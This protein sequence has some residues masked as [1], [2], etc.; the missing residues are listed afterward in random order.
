MTNGGRRTA[1]EMSEITNEQVLLAI[2][3]LRGEME[4]LMVKAVPAP[5]PAGPDVEM[6]R[7][8]LEELHDYIRR[9]KL[10]VAA[11]RHPR[12]GSDRLVAATCELDAVVGATEQATNGILQ[13]AEEIEAL[14]GRLRNAVQ[15]PAASEIADHMTDA[16]MKIFEHCGFQDITGQRVNKVVNTL[17]YIEERIGSIVRIWGEETFHA[18]PLPSGED[19]DSDRDLLN[20]P[21]LDGDSVS[22]SMID[23]LLAAMEKPADPAVGRGSTCPLP[24]VAAEADGEIKLAEKDLAGRLRIFLDYEIEWNDRFREMNSDGAGLAAL[25][26]ERAVYEHDLGIEALVGRIGHLREVRTVLSELLGM[27]ASGTPRDEVVARVLRFFTVPCDDGIASDH[28]LFRMEALRLADGL[29]EWGEMPEREA[30]L[31]MEI[32][33]SWRN[34]E[35][36]AALMTSAERTAE[37]L[38]MIRA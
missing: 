35:A 12:A 3:S 28:A 7:R 25:Q 16:V 13:S 18:L 17:R 30:D 21:Q 14:A 9:T 33:A 31:D 26:E 19:T 27:S 34:L 4:H 20:G 29:R 15:D 11:L 24:S 37:P 22:Q 2:L 38:D 1:R 32:T 10:E 5:S 36:M 8:E 6:L 23:D